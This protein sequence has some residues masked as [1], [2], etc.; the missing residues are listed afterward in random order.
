MCYAQKGSKMKNLTFATLNREIALENA[1]YNIWAEC[2]FNE[3]PEN[4]KVK[5]TYGD[6]EFSIKY[7]YANEEILNEIGHYYFTED[8][9]VVIYLDDPVH[10]QK[11][12]A[13]ERTHDY[14]EIAYM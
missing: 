12:I 9:N 10:C 7:V 1:I 8:A 14:M 4:E 13:F 6:G 3:C 5:I 2:V 11:F